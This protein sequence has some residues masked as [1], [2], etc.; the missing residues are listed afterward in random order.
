MAEVL[1]GPARYVQGPG[2]AGMMEEAIRRADA[3]GQGG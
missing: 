3:A 1:A 2:W